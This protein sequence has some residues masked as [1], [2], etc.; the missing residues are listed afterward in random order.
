MAECLL[1]PS[2]SV[3]EP[4]YNKMDMFPIPSVEGRSFR[5]ACTG[6]RFVVHPRALTHPMV[7]GADEARGCIVQDSE[8][9]Q[10]VKSVTRTPKKVGPE[11][12][13]LQE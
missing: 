4:I 10:V 13:S 2:Y 12:L 9:T 6:Q 7:R 11:A 5:P 1:P 8:L 3:R